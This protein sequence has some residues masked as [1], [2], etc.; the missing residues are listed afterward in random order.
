MMADSKSATAPD[1]VPQERDFLLMVA[2]KPQETW[3]S[4]GAAM[5]AVM[6]SMK[7]RGLV[8]K[9]H[10]STMLTDTGAA[11]VQAIIDSRTSKK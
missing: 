5:G 6:E 3:Q 9:Q 11:A 8:T 2:G 10:G 4:W 7:G 1:L